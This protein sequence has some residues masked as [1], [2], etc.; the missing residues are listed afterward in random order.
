MP[1][2]S[3]SSRAECSSKS[4]FLRALLKKVAYMMPSAAGKVI[5]IT[6][7]PSDVGAKTTVARFSLLTSGPGT[8]LPG[9]G[10]PYE[11]AKAVGLC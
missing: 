7:I 8:G 6:S 3:A 4:W 10:V 1:S 11:A 9:V 5:F 2:A